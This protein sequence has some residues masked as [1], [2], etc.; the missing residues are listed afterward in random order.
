MT[1][2]PCDGVWRLATFSRL[3]PHQATLIE[4][5]LIICRRSVNAPSESP[6]HPAAMLPQS[7]R[8]Q[9]D[10][11]RQCRHW[12][13]R[14][15]HFHPRAGQGRPVRASPGQWSPVLPE[16]RSNPLAAPLQPGTL[17]ARGRSGA[18]QT[19]GTRGRPRGPARPRPKARLPS[20]PSL[21]FCC[22]FV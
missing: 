8:G 2:G 13:S 9:G 10:S 17:R 5:C 18:E 15:I 16:R 6:G 3:G 7:D 1:G 12:R 19:G 20:L 14:V 22:F 21:P 4:A 11:G